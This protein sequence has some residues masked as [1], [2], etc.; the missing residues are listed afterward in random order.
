VNNDGYDDVVVGAPHNSTLKGSAHLY[1]GSSTGLSASPS[2]TAESDIVN[3]SFG[4]SVSSAGDVNNDGYDDVVVGAY[5]YSYTMTDEG[6]VFLYLG[7]PA[8]LSA[9]PSW[10]AEGNQAGALFGRSV[11]SAGDVNGDGYSE[12]I[13]GAPWYDN[14]QKDEGRVFVYGEFAQIP[15]FNML[16]IPVVGAIAIVVALRRTQIKRRDR[17]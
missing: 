13:V 15:E 7:S 4:W 5:T 17:T 14:V 11:S 16:L 1:L 3:T 9:T 2:W 6:R 10:T 12:V 8:G